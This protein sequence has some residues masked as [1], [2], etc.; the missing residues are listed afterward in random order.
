M[1]LQSMCG[2][3]AL[4]VKNNN[5]MNEYIQTLMTTISPHFAKGQKRGPEH[6]TLELLNEYTIFGFHRLAINGLDTVSNQPICIDGVYLICNGEIYNY[7]KLFSQLSI[8]PTTNSDCEVIIHM[9]L[10]YGIEYTLQNLD[11]VFGFVLYDTNINKYY[12]A[13]DPFGVR[14]IYLGHH[15]DYMVVSSELKQIHTICNPMTC[16]QFKPGTY[17]ECD[18]RNNALYA[19]NY[20]QYT[21]FNYLQSEHTLS[22]NGSRSRLMNSGDDCYYQLIYTALYEAVKKRVITSDRKIACLLSGGLDSSLITALVAKFVPKGQLETYS[23]G[24]TGGEDLQYAKMVAQHIGSKH[25]EIIL[26]EQEFL[27]AIPDVIYT[28]ESYDTTTIRASVGNYLIAQYISKNSDAK[29]IFNGDGSDELTGGYMYFHNSPSAMEFDYE[30]KRLLR[31]IYHY[32]VLRSDRCVSSHG[33]EPRTP[34]LDRNFV[35]QYLSIPSDVRFHNNNNEK[36]IEKY[37]LRS[38]IENQ[39]VGLLP[40]CVLWRNKEAFSDGVSSNNKSWYQIIQEYVSHNHFMSLY[41]EQQKYSFNTPTSMEQVYYRQIFDSY[42]PK[43]SHVI[44]YFWMPRFCDAEDSSART[45]DVYK[46]KHENT[47][48]YDTSDS[49]SQNCDSKGIFLQDSDEN[50]QKYYDENGN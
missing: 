6:T 34:F 44:P 15:D 10:R 50:L 40:R 37:L 2:I 36:N 32:D 18:Y 1:I 4:L 25:T 42:F 48:T 28:I 8:N 41:D 45:L 29:V 30:C 38:A 20:N 16:V 3:F 33:L 9:Y 46:E 22:N 11:G 47:T 19:S 12:I 31:N 49:D 39:D 17:V 7:K 23:I 5:L 14:P 24:M 43:C 13:R 21:T 27:S 26:T 35:H